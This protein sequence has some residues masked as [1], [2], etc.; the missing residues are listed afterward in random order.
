MQGPV[1]VLYHL[2]ALTSEAPRRSFGGRA[3]PDWGGAFT[4]A[5]SED[6]EMSDVRIL[7]VDDDAHIR[8]LLRDALKLQGYEVEV[9]ADGVDAAKLLRDK[10]FNI[11]VTDLQM[12]RMDGRKLAEMCGQIRPGIGLIIMTA[13]PSEA[14]VLE[15]FRYG[16]V[17]YLVKPIDLRDLYR[18]VKKVERDRRDLEA[19]SGEVGRDPAIRIQSPRP[20]WIEFE[21]PS[22][23][24][25]LERFTNLFEV[26]VRKG[27]DRDILDDVRI[28]VQEL[29]SNAIEWGNEGDPRRP[30]RISAIIEPEQLVIV[31]EDQGGGFKPDGVPDPI[32][33]PEGVAEE[34]R[35][36]GKRPGGYGIAM[37]KAAMNNIFYNQAGNTVVITKKL[38]R[39]PDLSDLIGGSPLNLK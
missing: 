32:V 38:N 2:P 31:V 8:T 3:R 25:F 22:H 27:V 35:T 16:A 6:R 19:A 18:A 13:H 39:P 17:A 11:L 26:L 29:G 34:R 24:M 20:G 21:A 28:A 12:P 33:D 7:A 30:I 10:D 5:L 1:T 9:A 23:Q 37:A 36:S 14:T 15:T 4:G